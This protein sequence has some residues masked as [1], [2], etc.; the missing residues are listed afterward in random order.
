MVYIQRFIDFV[1]FLQKHNI[2]VLLQKPYKMQK[3][4]YWKTNVITIKIDRPGP[5]NPP[6]EIIFVGIRFSLKP[7]I[8][9]MDVFK[10]PWFL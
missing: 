2:Q 8:A 1:A 5:H 4:N 9:M 6:P 3:Q 10:K 7:D